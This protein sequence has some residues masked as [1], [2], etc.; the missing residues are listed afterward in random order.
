MLVAPSGAEDGPHSA[1]EFGHEKDGIYVKA[2]YGSRP[3]ILRIVQQRG[4]RI[5]TLDGE[6]KSFEYTI[7]PF[8]SV[9]R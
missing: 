9:V 4:D 5:T 1:D 8:R 2:G 6:G 7:V 3:L